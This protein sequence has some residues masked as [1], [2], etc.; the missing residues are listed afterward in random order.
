MTERLDLPRGK[1]FREQ[2][3]QGQK[4]FWR[5][6]RGAE[7]TPKHVE[8]KKSLEHKEHQRLFGFVERRQVRW[9]SLKN[10]QSLWAQSD[11]T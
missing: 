11:E 3:L 9:Q 8:N 10:F 5:Q 7:E 2:P 1:R 6:E 4:G